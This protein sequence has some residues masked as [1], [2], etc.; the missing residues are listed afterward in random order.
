MADHDRVEGAAKNMGGKVKEAAGNVTGDEK[1]KAEGKADQLEGKV[2]N[3]V[4]GVKDAL[5]GKD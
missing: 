2:Q 4:G 3:T 5:R 1:L